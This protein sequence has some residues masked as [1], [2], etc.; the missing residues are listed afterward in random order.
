MEDIITIQDQ[1]PDFNLEDKV[2]EKEEAYMNLAGLSNNVIKFNGLNYADWSEQIQFQLGVLDLDMAIM[3]D[4]IPAAIIET[5]TND[6]K[7]LYEAWHRSNRLS[8]NLMCMSMVENV[9]PSMPRTEN[10]KEFMKMIKEY[11]QSDITDKSIVGTLMSE[12]TTKK[13]D[14]SQ[15]IHE[16][17]TGMANIAAR[18]KSMGMEVNESFLV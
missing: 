11:S 8:L 17:V 5:S 7:S 4:E 14:W 13:F 3:M 9:K 12:L 18:L 6:E 2:A 1:Y 10:A 15:P 16:H